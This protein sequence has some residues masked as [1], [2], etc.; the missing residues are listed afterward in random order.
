[1]HGGLPKP[2]GHWQIAYACESHAR[3]YGDG[4]VVGT[5]FSSDTFLIVFNAQME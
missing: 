2:F 1:L 4:C 5:F 3:W